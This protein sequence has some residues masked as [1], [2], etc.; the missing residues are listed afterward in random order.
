MNYTKKQIRELSALYNINL[1]TLLSQQ[2]NGKQAVDL[3][4]IKNICIDK[5]VTLEQF[6]K[7]FK[8][9]TLTNRII[10][11]G[12]KPYSALSSLELEMLSIENENGYFIDET[13]YE[14]RKLI[15]EIRKK[16]W[17]S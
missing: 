5:E 2:K 8:E 13:L 10:E 12:Q 6:L 15:E 11:A 1:N 16:W 4:V 17:T 7:L 3:V 9:K 14:N